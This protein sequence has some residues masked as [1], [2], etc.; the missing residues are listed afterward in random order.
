MASD[1][2]PGRSQANQDIV[3]VDVPIHA[4]TPV[5]TRTAKKAVFARLEANIRSLGLL[6]PLLI[7]RHKKHHF[8]IDGYLRYVILQ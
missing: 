1:A 7:Y 5:R 3:T 6:E 4:L 2:L 8:I